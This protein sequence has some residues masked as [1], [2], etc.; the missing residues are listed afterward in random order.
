MA[1]LGGS[2]PWI[3]EIWSGVAERPAIAAAGPPGIMWIMPKVEG[4][5]AGHDKNRHRACN[6]VR[7][8]AD[9]VRPRRLSFLEPYV[10]PPWDVEG[11]EALDVRT[12]RLPEVSEPKGSA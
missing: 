6:A 3:R 8:G 10:V 9:H 2:R 4:G 7:D 12:H 1:V 11:R 5:Q